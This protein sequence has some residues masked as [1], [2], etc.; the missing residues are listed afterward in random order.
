MITVRTW[1]GTS[2]TPISTKSSAALHARSAR[3]EQGVRRRMGAAGDALAAHGL[4]PA[5]LARGT[6]WHIEAW[7]GVNFGHKVA[8]RAAAKAAKEAGDAKHIG[9]MWKMLTV[10]AWARVGAAG[11]TPAPPPGTVT[12]TVATS[13]TA[14]TS[15]RR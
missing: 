5:R 14:P 12:D 2:V 9:E 4:A 11:S 3:N 1:D 10:D 15:D 7:G 8:G 13:D 6:D